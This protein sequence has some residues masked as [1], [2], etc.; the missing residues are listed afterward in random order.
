M[1]LYKVCS[2]E[3][4][5]KVAEGRLHPVSCRHNLFLDMGSFMLPLNFPNISC[6]GAS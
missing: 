5:H 1:P 3:I 4:E 2:W 6:Q